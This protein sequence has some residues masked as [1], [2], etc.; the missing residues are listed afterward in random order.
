M[1]PLY[2]NNGGLFPGFSENDIK[3]DSDARGG[4]QF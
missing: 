3:K 1:I 2:F 4:V